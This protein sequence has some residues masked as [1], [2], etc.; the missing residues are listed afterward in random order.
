[1]AVNYKYII[2]FVSNHAGFKKGIEDVAKETKA[3]EAGVVKLAGTVKNDIAGA[4]QAMSR[5]AQGD[6]TALPGVFKAGSSTAGI[7]SKSLHGIKAALIATGIGAIVVAIGTAIGALTRYFKGTEEG[8]IVFAQ[9]MNKVKAYTEPVLQL[10]GKLGKSLVQLFKGDFQGAWSTVKE[11]F[12]QV[13]DGIKNN[14]KNLEELN[15]L[16]AEI[17]A[18]R[19]QAAS[20]EKRLMAEISDLRNKAKDTENYTAQE[21]LRFADLAIAKQRELGTIKGKLADDELRIA[22][23]KKSFGDNDIATND[24]IGRAHV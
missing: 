19:R 5:F 1:M 21:N 17:V 14:I 12:S 24:Q 23:I 20:E 4:G 11:S 10:F 6:I 3:A 18:K 16:E 2:D 13:D 9:V 15:K 8:Q 22:E 7:F